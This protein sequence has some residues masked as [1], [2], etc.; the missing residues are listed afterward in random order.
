MT[1]LDLMNRFPPFCC[2][3]VA[4]E[5]R[6]RRGLSHA[7]IARRAGIT[8]KTVERLSMKTDWSGVSVSKAV[9]FAIACGV[10]HLKMARQIDYMKRR[11]MVHIRNAPAAQKAFYARLFQLKPSQ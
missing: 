8:R 10:N 3:L 11:G 7:E 5:R 9:R 2:R 6:G 4:R 1:A